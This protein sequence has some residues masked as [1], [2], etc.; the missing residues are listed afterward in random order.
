M[1]KIQDN[2]NKFNKIIHE[3]GLSKET[4]CLAPY[5][6]L[7]LDQSGEM[8]SCYRG[9]KTL[10]NWKNRDSR[11]EF[12]NEEYQN[13][14]QQ[15]YDDKKHENCKSCWSAES[16]GS[17]SPRQ[18][19]FDQVYGDYG[20]EYVKN[21]LTKIKQNPKLGELTDIE[22][23]EI[24]TSSLCNLKCMHCGPGNSTQWIQMLSN[25]QTMYDEVR[26]FIADP[27]STDDTMAKDLPKVYKSSLS[28]DGQYADTVKLAMRHSKIVQFSGGEPLLDPKHKGWLEYLQH[29]AE[30]QTLD[31]NSNLN[32]HDLEEY[33]P[34]WKNFKRVN[35]RISI[36]SAP[37]TYK[38]FRRLGDFSLVEDNIKKIQNNF[39]SPQMFMTGSITFNMF[40]ALRWQEIFDWW[41]KNNVILH[42]SLVI[43][44]PTSAIHLPDSLKQLCI[45]TMQSTI[46]WF[47]DADEED[48]FADQWKRSTQD[49]LNYIKNDMKGEQLSNNTVLYLKSFDRHT[50]LKTIDFFPELEKFL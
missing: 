3:L 46:D 38:Y 31:Y 5:I 30:R 23:T 49:C 29:S 16:K 11:K 32:I 33:F 36:D 44:H 18:R 22:R 8:Y 10:G 50:D 37:S 6:N 9:K 39:S 25:N 15:L 1:N 42:T 48:I 17:I 40:S 12:N 45:D 4:F 24:R 28:S 26:S 14:R 13:L 19:F 7:D 20:S 47:K 35:L 34:L 2:V 21:L 27:I 41:R 43:D